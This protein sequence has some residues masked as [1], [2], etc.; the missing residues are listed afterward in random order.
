VPTE[1]EEY[2]NTAGYR[3]VW[4][5]NIHEFDKEE[6]HCGWVQVW[7]RARAM[8]EYVYMNFS[9]YEWKNKKISLT[10]NGEKLEEIN[11]SINT[12]PAAQTPHGYWTNDTSYVINAADNLYM[13]GTNFNYPC[14]PTYQPEK[15]WEYH[16][17]PTPNTMSTMPSLQKCT[18]FVKIPAKVFAGDIKWCSSVRIV[19]N[20]ETGAHGIMAN[21]EDCTIKIRDNNNSARALSVSAGSYQFVQ[22]LTGIA[23]EFKGEGFYGDCADELE[24]QEIVPLEKGYDTGKVAIVDERSTGSDGSNGASFK[25]QF[26]SFQDIFK[27]KTSQIIFWVV[28]GIV[29]LVVLIVLIIGIKYACHK[30]H[31]SG[32]V[33]P[34]TIKTFG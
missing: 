10:Y 3:Q 30:T 32:C 9:R 15:H 14:I 16:I 18:V 12:S 29:I 21:L 20:T 28:V 1:Y 24:F 4:Q 17:M 11:T 23:C 22:G 27:S 31:I 7:W 5:K 33:I 26:P 34:S 8:C 2:S 25:F 6:H 19:L 13:E